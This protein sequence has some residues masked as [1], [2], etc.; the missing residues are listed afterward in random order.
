[1]R[2]KNQI[3][4]GWAASKI[5]EVCKSSQYGYTAKAGVSGRV[6]FLRTTDITSGSIN[7][8][9]VPYC[10]IPEVD[11]SKYLLKDGDVVIS[12]AGSVGFSH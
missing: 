9:T 6:H 8:N 12:R 5:G 11:E 1:M 10:D 7:W 2:A 3:P 4:Q